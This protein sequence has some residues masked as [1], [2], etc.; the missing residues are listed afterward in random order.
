MAENPHTKH[1]QRVME[2]FRQFGLSVFSDHEV[3]EL[4]LFFAIPR[5]DTNETAHRLVRQFGSLHKVFEAPVEQLMEVEGIGQRSAD[6]IK[7][8]FEMLSRY[9]ADIVKMEQHSDKLTSVDRIGEYFVPQLMSERDEVLLA[10]YLDGA[11]RVLKC[12]EIARGG[13][14][15]VSIDPYK[16]ATGALLCHAAGV[17][18]AHNHPNGMAK[19][20]EEDIDATRMLERTLTGLGIQLVDHCVVARD[21]HFSIC[22]LLH[23]QFG[24]RR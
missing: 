15:Q 24:L 5:A 20:S 21:K 3:L 12:E 22:R 8:T 10:A 18:I 23:R 1:R 17:A 14:A 13:H 7:L 2:K 9:Q 6:L 4:L 19:P 16:I 11:G